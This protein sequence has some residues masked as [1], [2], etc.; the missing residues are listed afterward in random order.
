MKRQL[1]IS[2]PVT[3]EFNHYPALPSCGNSPREPEQVEITGLYL[4][5]GI[6]EAVSIGF[7]LPKINRQEIG[8]QILEEIQNESE[9]AA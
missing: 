1:T 3:V 2:I 8:E 4:A 6:H 9:D 5:K 7:M